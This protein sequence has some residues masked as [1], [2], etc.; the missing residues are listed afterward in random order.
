MSNAKIYHI[1]TIPFLKPLD[2]T[3][4]KINTLSLVKI[5][6]QQKQLVLRDESNAHVTLS[7]PVIPDV[8]ARL[9]FEK[10]SK[11]FSGKVDCLKGQNDK[12]EML[13]IRIFIR[14]VWF[15]K[16]CNKQQEIEYFAQKR[17]LETLLQYRF[18]TVLSLPIFNVSPEIN[19]S[20][21]ILEQSDDIQSLDYKFLTRTNII[22]MDKSLT[23]ELPNNTKYTN[24][25]NS[26]YTDNTIWVRQ[27]AAIIRS[28][29]FQEQVSSMVRS[30]Q[31]NDSVTD[32][33]ALD[34][35]V[36][37]IHPWSIDIW[38]DAITASSQTFYY[39]S[40]RDSYNQFSMFDVHLYA[41]ILVSRIF[42]RSNYYQKYSKVKF[43]RKICKQYLSTLNC[44]TDVDV[45]TLTAELFSMKA[46]SVRN[47]PFHFFNWKRY[48]VTSGKI[49]PF[50]FVPS[51]STWCILTCPND[52]VSTLNLRSII[53][54]CFHELPATRKRKKKKPSNLLVIKDPCIKK[55]LQLCT[56]N[57]PL[58]YFNFGFE[59]PTLIHLKYQKIEIK[60]NCFEMNVFNSTSIILTQEQKMLFFIHP[61]RINLTENNLL[62]TYTVHQYQ[63]Y[64]SSE[65]THSLSQ[66]SL[67]LKIFEDQLKLL[68]DMCL[69]CN[70]DM[71]EIQVIQDD[72]EKLVKKCSSYT[73]EINT[74]PSN[75][76]HTSSS[77]VLKK[78]YKKLKIKTKANLEILRFQIRSLL[79]SQR[80]L[81]Y[82]KRT[83]T[84]SQN[85][86]CPICMDDMVACTILNCGH[87]FCHGCILQIHKD[88]QNCP[89]CKQHIEKITRLIE[90][91]E[92]VA[93]LDYSKSALTSF[94]Y[95]LIENA[96]RRFWILCEFKSVAAHI[97]EI[98]ERYFDTITV[99]FWN[100][101]LPDFEILQKAD[102][103]V[104]HLSLEISTLPHI[105]PEMSDLILLTRTINIS[106][107]KHDQFSW[108][109]SLIPPKVNITDIQI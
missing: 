91:V 28:N 61:T 7:F 83:L 16:K 97:A 76:S 65:L 39:V 75:L 79:E 69:L 60:P 58:S 63:T 3:D 94:L 77:K 81:T 98:I 78:Q 82:S 90:S 25:A 59:R 42:S 89:V 99:I 71:T 14:R 92:Q 62:S 24:T 10:Y 6:V 84:K 30:F 68:I 37:I 43:K 53:L 44:P 51:L 18:D 23:V 22:L 88:C 45:Q 55:M 70:S 38:R 86:A 107:S 5:N 26:R 56:F 19:R 9:Q 29:K 85:T 102:V 104:S 52:V 2:L 49:P 20:S 72:F 27:T 46:P 96:K 106:K 54:F 41:Y 12:F 17:F 8:L 31:M 15:F 74:L 36:V 95:S 47:A 87:Q 4:K 1:V 93:D 40:D 109:M 48:V 13:Q 21:M 103:L 34:S 32:L 35:T 50:R 67:K 108:V 66:I 11:V 105:L 64:I 57:V 73:M 33:K 101:K 100:K 80:Q